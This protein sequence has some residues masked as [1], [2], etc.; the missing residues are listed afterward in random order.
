MAF[1]LKFDVATV[2][3][4]VSVGLIIVALVI[5]F[6]FGSKIPFTT[7]EI[8]FAAVCLALSYALSFIKFFSMPQ[9][10]SVTPASALPLLIYA[11]YFGW[12]KGLVVGFIYSLLQIMQKPEL[13]HP[14]QVLLDYPLAYTSIFVVGF[15]RPLG[16]PGFYAGITAY[17]IIRYFCHV[18]S[19]AVF[20]GEYA[21]EGWAAWPY[22]FVYNTTTLVELAVTLLIGVL[23]FSSNSFVNQLE[24]FVANAKQPLYQKIKD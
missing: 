20:F 8:A 11:Y 18:V 10:G 1:L 5:I 3:I 19:G 22:S 6:A 7:K 14:V 13:Y 15:F 21:W 9:G 4:P 12:K 16:K 23:L 17:G 24:S 2:T